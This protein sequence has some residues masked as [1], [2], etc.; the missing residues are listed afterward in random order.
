MK[1]SAQPG[2]QTTFLSTPADIAIYGGA[3]GGGKTFALIAEALRNVH[4]PRFG[5]VIFRRTS[6]A[7]RREG[8]LW[9]STLNLYP[10]FGGRGSSNVLKW[11]FPSGANVSMAGMEHEKDRFGW[12]GSQIAYIGFDELTHFSAT[13]FWYMLGRNRSDSGVPGFIRATCNPDPDSWVRTFIKWWIDDKTG[14]A[15]PGRSG[16]IRWFVRINDEL[17]WAFTAKELK[18]KFGSDTHPKSVTFIP[19]SVYD[20]K[21]LLETDPAYLSNL[22][23][24]QKIEREQLLNGNWNIRPSAGMFFRREWMEKVKAAPADAVR[25]RYW[26]RAATQKTATNDP[27]A[28][29]GVK[30]A[31][32]RD[33]IFYIED[34]RKMFSSPMA[35]DAAIFKTGTQDGVECRIG[36][37][38]DPGSAGVYEAQATAAKLAGFVVTFGPAT[39]DKKTRAKPVSAQCEAGNVK[40]VEGEWNEDFL[41]VLENFGSDEGHDDEADGLSGAFEMITKGRNVLLA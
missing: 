1:L 34:C 4:N 2:P 19:A 37:N 11:T 39:G 29:V 25:V 28:T 6:V 32:G 18:E 30:L 24:L 38:Q 15:I 40:Y 9:D 3:A 41:R 8:G 13:Q 21:V 33:G 12:Q 17:H 27:D 35:V 7:I 26:D 5:A 23:A 10:L 31:R 14:L 20:N 22:M 16:V 36:Y